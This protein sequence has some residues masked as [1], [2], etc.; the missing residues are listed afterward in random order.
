MENSTTV[1]RAVKLLFELGASPGGLTA[2]ELAKRLDTQRPPLYRLLQTLSAYRL[3]RRDELKLYT[4]SVGVL[5]L[6]RAVSEPLDALVRPILQTAADQ[7]GLSAMLLLA[8]GDALVT[9]LSVT[10]RT[11]GMHLASTPGF[12]HPTGPTAPRLAVLSLRS[13]KTD[14]SPEIVAARAAGYAVT[15]GAAIPGRTALASPVLVGSN[16]Q[17]GAVLLISFQDDV[18]EAVEIC[19]HTAQTITRLFQVSS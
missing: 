12:V 16:R 19:R 14:D 5:E 13:P 6:A 15:T 17:E 4:L 10:P 1:E 9:V 8:E 2:T 11:P 7:T 3:I 18:E